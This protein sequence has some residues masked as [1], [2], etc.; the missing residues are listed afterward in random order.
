[1]SKIVFMG[2]PDFSTGILEML[3]EEHEVIAVVTQP[4]RPVGRKKVLTPPPVKKVAVKHNIPVYQPEKLNHSP[5]LEEIINLQPDLIVTAAFGQLL[6]KSLLD[7]PKYKAVNVHASLLPKYR[8]GAPIHYAVMNGEKKTGVTIMYM[9]EK[10][11]AGNIISQDEID[12]K[13]NDTVGDVHDQLAVLGTA[14]LKRTLPPIFNGTNDSIPQDESL[15]SFASNISR[16]DERIDWTQDAESIHNHIRGLS[17][18]PVAYTT[19][20]DKNMKLWRSEIVRNVKGNPGEIVET[21]KSAI[22]V[23]TGSEDGVALTEIQL[24]GKKRVQTRDYLS[25]LQSKIDG[26]KLI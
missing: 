18:W 6:P 17:P 21:T 23:A 26:T 7:T 5:E 16:E 20:N 25:G 15:V 22:I 4:D 9:A 19:M 14:L 24:A 10:L 12:I 8:G 1:M 2:T 13:E 3:I 11:D